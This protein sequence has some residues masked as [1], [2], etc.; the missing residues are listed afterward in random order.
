[1]PVRRWPAALA[2]ALALLLAAAPAQ[3]A[4][5]PPGQPVA[6][7]QALKAARWQI[8]G[9]AAD[10]GRQALAI[11]LLDCLADP[12]PALR[13]G[14]AF[15]ALQAWMRGRQLETATVRDIGQRLQ[16]VLAAPADDAGFAQ[17]F[18]ALVLADVARVDRLQPFLPADERAALVA[19]AARYLAGVRDYRGFD[20][21]SGWR[22]GVAHAADLAL[23]LSLNPALEPAQAEALRS[24][25]AAQVMPAGV[26][27]WRFGEPERL[28][29]PVFYLARRSWW[30]AADWQAWFEALTAQRARPAQPTAESLAQRHNLGAFLSALYVAA[31]ESS[32]EPTRAR[33]LP[34]LRQAIKALD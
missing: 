3:A 22:H 27:A 18:A 19:Q 6:A 5:P 26:H 29:A 14:V 1:M 2:L 4:C 30:T 23:Q 24:A 16:R 34:G 28:M 12:D 31:Q 21:R 10:A 17:P 20:P 25:I 13:D 8:A 32:D 7:L 33:L 15:E 9:P 11:G